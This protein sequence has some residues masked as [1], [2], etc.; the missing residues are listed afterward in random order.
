MA[1][2]T[3]T[4]H[5]PYGADYGWIDS[6]PSVTIFLLSEEYEV[7]AGGRQLAKCQ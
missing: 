6:G 1:K 3:L 4:P 2:G 5:H 7:I